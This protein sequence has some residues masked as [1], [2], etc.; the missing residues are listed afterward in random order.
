M[1]TNKDEYREH[2]EELS[3]EELLGEDLLASKA[4]DEI[5]GRLD[6]IRADLESLDYEELLGH[7]H[8]EYLAEQEI[9]KRLNAFE[10]S[11]EQMAG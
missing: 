1:F 7:H 8:L 2:L 10:E 11:S 3:Y 4:E 6:A 9:E 5:E